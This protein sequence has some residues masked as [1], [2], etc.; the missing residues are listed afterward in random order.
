ME[1]DKGDTLMLARTALSALIVI[2]TLILTLL[3]AFGAEEFPY[4][5]Q[6]GLEVIP[7][8]GSTTVIMVSEIAP[9]S[10]ADKAGVKVYDLIFQVN[11]TDVTSPQTLEQ[12]L[13]K[14][15]KAKEL[16]LKVFSNGENK[17]LTIK[18]HP[19]L[20]PGG[21]PPPRSN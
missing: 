18:R 9:R 14:H 7:P 5:K 16:I 20:P 11:G 6:L 17:L 21:N 19:A 2:P 12:A 13:A 15:V 3:S 8:C 4:T 10:S 1:P